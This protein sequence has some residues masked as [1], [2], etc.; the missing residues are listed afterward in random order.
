MRRLFKQLELLECNLVK[1]TQSVSESLELLHKGIIQLRIML[2][3]TVVLCLMLIILLLIPRGRES[4]LSG[5]PSSLKIQKENKLSALNVP[6]AR[7]KNPE[8]KYLVYI[9]K[10]VCPVGMFLVAPLEIPVLRPISL[11][12]PRSFGADQCASSEGFLVTFTP[13]FRVRTSEESILDLGFLSEDSR[14]TSHFKMNQRSLRQA[15]AN[16]WTS[17]GSNPGRRQ[18]SGFPQE[19]RSASNQIGLLDEPQPVSGPRSSFR[20]HLIVRKY[21]IG[22]QGSP[23]FLNVMIPG[24]FP[25]RVGI[26]V[27]L[28]P[29]DEGRI[30]TGRNPTR[31]NDETVV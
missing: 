31:G 13:P 20:D 22:P 19:L 26:M 10:V 15:L 11:L 3:L 21:I 28:N 2:G 1:Q 9:L 23:F 17:G 30:G 8:V 7:T 14:S 27:A 18:S 4:T 6:I 12:S 5:N 25:G 16:C 29:S 24:F